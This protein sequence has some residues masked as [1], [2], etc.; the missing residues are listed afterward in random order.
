MK[1]QE[2][3]M[4]AE[5]GKARR[6]TRAGPFL[7][8]LFFAA[9]QAPAALLWLLA[10]IPSGSEPAAVACPSP[11]SCIAVGQA[12]L[13]LVSQNGGQQW[14]P[15]N[16]GLGAA[17]ANFNLTSIACLSGGQCTIVGNQGLILQSTNG[18]QSFSI[19]NVTTNG[20]LTFNEVV[21]Q[22]SGTPACA[23]VGDNNTLLLQSSAGAPWTPDLNV[24][25]AAIGPANFNQV[26]LLGSSLWIAASTTSGTGMNA[27]LYSGDGGQSWRLLVVPQALASQGVSGVG[28]LSVS[29]CYVDGTGALLETT[30]GGATWSSSLLLGAG[31]P[32]CPR[33]SRESTS[34]RGAPSMPTGRTELST[35]LHPSPGGPCRG[36]RP[37]PRSFLR[38]PPSSILPAWSAPRPSPATSRETPLPFR[39]ESSTLAPAVRRGPDRQGFPENSRPRPAHEHIC[40][41]DHREVFTASCQ[42][43]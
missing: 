25:T 27:L 34:V 13:F 22:N 1:A 23:I 8:L 43:L 3:K 6:G 26:S 12:G 39:E 5:S 36:R 2:G 20:N 14:L 37:F 29:T 31:G 33:R 28:C 16:S 35:S 15:A 18:G 42:C 10:F 19:T 24:L 32:R 38:R 4:L 17:L 11:Q 9:C 30:D 41:L 7:L 40:A 21:C